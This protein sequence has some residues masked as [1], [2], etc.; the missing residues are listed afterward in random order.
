MN[1]EPHIIEISTNSFNLNECNDTNIENFE[2]FGLGTFCDMYKTKSGCILRTDEN[3]RDWPCILI[4]EERGNEE[5]GDGEIGKCISKS[6]NL[7][8]IF[9][10]YR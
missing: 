10:V 6:V 8:K 1:N 4:I 2:F 5:E 7:L 3:A 9:N